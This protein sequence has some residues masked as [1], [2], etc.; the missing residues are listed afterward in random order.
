MYVRTGDFYFFEV[1][2][3]VRSLLAGPL[4]NMTLEYNMINIIRVDFLMYA[5]Y[6][7]GSVLCT[8]WQ[9]TLFGNYKEDA[10]KETHFDVQTCLHRLLVTGNVHWNCKFHD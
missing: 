2:K 7:L 9:D 6:F 10:A 5:T 8:I 4:K 3:S 1:S